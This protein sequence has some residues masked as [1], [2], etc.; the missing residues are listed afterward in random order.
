MLC[1]FVD[2]TR[3]KQAE[4]YWPE[5]DEKAKFSAGKLLVINENTK[6]LYEEL[7]HRV[8]IMEGP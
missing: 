1:S 2:P 7:T 4:R 8:F 6:N 5:T 3:G